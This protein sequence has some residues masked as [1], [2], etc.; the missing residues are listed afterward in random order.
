M[1]KKMEL[2]LINGQFKM[3]PKEIPNRP[4][5]E[6]IPYFCKELKLSKK[7]MIKIEELKKK[8]LKKTSISEMGMVPKTFV[9][10]LIYISSVLCKE[11]RS[12]R[13]ICTVTATSELS[14]R[15]GSKYICDLLK[16]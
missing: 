9:V 10:S 3:V 12:Q 11:A 5:M 6:L 14:I 8:A 13:E 4:S 15:K 1:I 7:C 2:K 16:I